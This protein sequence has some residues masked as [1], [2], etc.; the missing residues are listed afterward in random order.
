MSFAAVARAK[1]EFE[2]LQQKTEDSLT[3]H[4]NE[5]RR[6]LENL[7]K[8]RGPDGGSPY[9]DFDLRDLLLRSLYK[10]LWGSWIASRRSN[11][12]LPTTFENL[13][14][15]LKQ[16]ES[17]MILEGPSIFESFMPSAHITKTS[18]KDFS[19]S[20][21]ITN[22]K[23]QTC[24]SP[25]TPKRATHLRCDPCQADFAAKRKSDRKKLKTSSPR[26]QPLMEIIER[27]SSSSSDVRELLC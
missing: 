12:N 26:A 13:V 2:K 16:A 19:S 14:L 4:V 5:F 7:I 8:I 9:A 3:E 25:F 10:P 20:S 1:D 18:P 24:G 22:S 17:D 23:C 27:Y 21:P 15:A 11:A 6:R